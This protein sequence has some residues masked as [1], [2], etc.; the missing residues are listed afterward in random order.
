MVAKDEEGKSAPVPGL[1]LTTK[2]EIRR[3]ARSIVR[4]KDGRNR[5]SRFNSKIFKIEDYIDL[6]DNSN[7]IIEMKDKS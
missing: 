6:F 1:I 5:T 7:S 2:S 3:F 4:Q